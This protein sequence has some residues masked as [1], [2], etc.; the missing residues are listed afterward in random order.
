LI[1]GSSVC[2]LKLLRIDVNFLL[3][4][5]VEA[6]TGFNEF[7]QYQRTVAALCVTNDSAERAIGLTTELNNNPRT[8]DEEEFQKLIQIGEENR[9]RVNSPIIIEYNLKLFEKI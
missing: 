8:K 6:W 5:E 4:N 3:N 1:D 2:A 7:V 9:E